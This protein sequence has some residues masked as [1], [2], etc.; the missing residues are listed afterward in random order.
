MKAVWMWHLG[1]GAQGGLGSAGGMVGLILKGFSS[2][3][4][5][6]AEHTA[7]H[8]SLCS[9]LGSLPSRAQGA[10]NHGVSHL[11]SQGRAG[12]VPVGGRAVWRG[13]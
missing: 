13:R 7:S 6:G 2:L 3:K 1:P 9:Y 12:I 4:G 8:K 10:E 5:C 11:S